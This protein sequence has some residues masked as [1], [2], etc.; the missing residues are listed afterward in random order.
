M[1]PVAVFVHVHYLDVWEDLAKVLAERM[2]V[3]FR[4]I[5]TSSLS[6]EEIV[7]PATPHLV[8]MI[9][10]TTEN[11]GRDIRP[12]LIAYG[13]VGGYS[14]G[15]KLHTKR[16]TH[17]FAGD[18]WRAEI[19]DSLLPREQGVTA[20]RRRME[21]VPHIGLV[22]PR[23][24][25]L[26]IGEWMLDNLEGVARLAETLSLNANRRVIAKGHF[27]AGSMFWF[28]RQAL[29]DFSAP[30]L[31]T[32]FEEET[33]Q[34]DGTTAHA[35]ERM[36]AFSAERRGFVAMPMDTLFEARPDMSDA[37]L[38]RL[39]RSRRAEVSRTLYPF[40]IHRFVHRYAPFLFSL[41]RQVPKTFRDRLRKRFGEPRY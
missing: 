36:F 13:S 28:R 1:E 34:V 14:I 16:S 17:L 8:E 3:P 40:A 29:E 37:A 7:A 12:F 32:M 6:G 41:Y 39:S 30:E 18:V 38:R 35:V 4:L 20:I 2:D 19:L 11:R 9:V 22:A 33:G 26:S 23:G 31:L 15:L 27:P 24:L 25:F 10:I 21:Q 5:V